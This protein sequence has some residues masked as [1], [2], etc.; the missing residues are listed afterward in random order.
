[1]TAGGFW[2]RRPDL[3]RAQEQSAEMG[4]ALKRAYPPDAA[5]DA[6]LER[7]LERLKALPTRKR[8]AGD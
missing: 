2:R 3:R 7:L 4:A 5:A 1:M 8:Q 6:E